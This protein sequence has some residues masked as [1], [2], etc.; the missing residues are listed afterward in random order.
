MHCMVFSPGK[1]DSQSF[2]GEGNARVR[3]DPVLSSKTAALT[4]LCQCCIF[5]KLVFI[6]QVCL[7]IQIRVAHP[8]SRFK[9]SRP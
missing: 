2:W 9:K 4:A 3:V 6:L 5:L 7:N 1:L 8:V